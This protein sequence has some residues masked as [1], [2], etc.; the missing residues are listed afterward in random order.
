MDKNKVRNLHC[1][2][3]DSYY[4]LLRTKLTAEATT[5]IKKTDAAT[6][7]TSMRQRTMT[8]MMTMVM[9]AMTKRS[10]IDGTIPIMCEAGVQPEDPPA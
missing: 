2:S 8:S 4:Q 9:T 1:H 7:V 3:R 6:K 10:E 5:S